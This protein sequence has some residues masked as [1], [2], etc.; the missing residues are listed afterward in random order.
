MSGYN[1]QGRMSTAPSS[2]PFDV[3]ESEV[4]SDYDVLDYAEGT[5]GREAL[6][7]DLNL[8]HSPEERDQ[9]LAAMDELIAAAREDL[10]AESG[11][12]E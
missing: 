2:E 6:I 5:P 8:T 10:D 9:L 3:D 11:D 12:D 4:E 1:D 7:T